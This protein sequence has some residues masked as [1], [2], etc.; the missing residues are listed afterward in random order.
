[1][2]VYLAWRLGAA[3]DREIALLSQACPLVERLALWS[4]ISLWLGEKALVTIKQSM[5]YVITL[6][7]ND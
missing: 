2:A 6:L 4:V 3:Y 1:M 5:Y 7:E